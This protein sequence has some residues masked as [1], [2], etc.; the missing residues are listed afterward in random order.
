MGSKRGNY[1]NDDGW[2]ENMDH[3]LNAGHALAELRLALDYAKDERQAHDIRTT[4]EELLA[5]SRGLQRLLESYGLLTAQ[6]ILF[7][8]SRWAIALTVLANRQ[9]SKQPSYSLEVRADFV[10]GGV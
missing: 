6:G 7:Y 2:S 8:D 5:S 9:R 3:E 10:C 1:R 4:M